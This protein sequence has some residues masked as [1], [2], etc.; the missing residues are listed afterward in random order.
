MVN[1]VYQ[2]QGT[3]GGM[4]AKEPINNN[5][6]AIVRWDS[7][8]IR[9]HYPA[10][11]TI[12][13]VVYDLEMQVF[14]QDTFSLNQGCLSNSAAV[15][16]MFKLTTDAP[17]LPFFAWQTAP[18]VTQVAVDLSL[19]LTPDFSMNNYI[20][21]YR[22]TDTI[23]PCTNFQCWYIAEVPVPINQKQLD[24]FTKMDPKTPWNNRA[25]GAGRDP[26]SD[27]LL[28]AQGLNVP[29]PTE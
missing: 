22:G 28:N 16:L 1:Y 27:E 14:M 15:S 8:S 7:D 24:Y 29:T 20:S 17:D 13:D 25:V 19:V 4:F 11:H 23:P 2:M 21:G 5:D 26:R 12:E 10:E 18:D 6:S 3:F 9:F